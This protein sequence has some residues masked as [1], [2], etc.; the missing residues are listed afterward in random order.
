MGDTVYSVSC[1][2]LSRVCGEAIYAQLFNSVFEGLSLSLLDLDVKVRKHDA[3][4]PYRPAPAILNNIG[5]GGGITLWG[6]GLLHILVR[7]G[8]QQYFLCEIGS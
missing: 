1:L 3:L 2:V 4:I 7:Y 6:L 8:I 5:E